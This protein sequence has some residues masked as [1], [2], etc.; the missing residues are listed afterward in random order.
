MLGSRDDVVLHLAVEYAELLA[1]AGDADAEVLVGFGVGLGG[2]EGLLADD[3]EL[4]L[5]HA[6]VYRGD[7]QINER[8]PIRPLKE[9]RV[10][11]EDR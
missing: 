7:Y 3:I 8:L 1:E 11:F 2:F 9:R 10:G 6:E 4:Q 5:A